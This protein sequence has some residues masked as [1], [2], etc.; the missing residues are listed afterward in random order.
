MNKYD[1]ALMQF[2]DVLQ[3]IANL[4]DNQEALNSPE[5]GWSPDVIFDD[6]MDAL[7]QF[8]QMIEKKIKLDIDALEEEASEPDAEHHVRQGALEVISRLEGTLEEHA[9][10]FNYARDFEFEDSYDY[11]CKP[12]YED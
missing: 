2:E 3:A 5:E 7:H 10:R 6:A 4:R 8:P 1:E 11:D 12:H 9:A